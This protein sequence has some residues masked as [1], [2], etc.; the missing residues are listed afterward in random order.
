MKKITISVFEALGE[1]IAV[2]EEQGRIIYNKIFMQLKNGNSVIL[3]FEGINTV[4]SIF[5][6][7]AIGSLYKEFN[8]DL[9]DAQVSFANC[10]KNVESVLEL[11]KEVAKEKYA[12]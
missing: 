8:S 6:R 2:V 1:P 4:L 11:V 7:E 9:I 10:S 3:D 5:A 12:K